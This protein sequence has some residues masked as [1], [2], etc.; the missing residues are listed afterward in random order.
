MSKL[1][2][3]LKSLVRWDKVA[4]MY[5]ISQSD[6]EIYHDHIVE[7]LIFGKEEDKIDIMNK[8][9]TDIEELKNEE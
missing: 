2:Q 6:L 7:I 4:E 5:N 9:K 8:I 3:N 1:L